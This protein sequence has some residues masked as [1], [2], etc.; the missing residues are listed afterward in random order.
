VSVSPV[1]KLSQLKKG[2]TLI[3]YGTRQ[4]STA[5]TAELIAKTLRAEYDLDVDVRDLKRESTDP[6]GYD[7]IIIGSGIAAD[8]WTGEAQRY[9]DTDLQGKRVAVFVSAA[10]TAGKARRNGDEKSYQETVKRYIDD[11]VSKRGLKLISERAFGGKMSFFGKVIIDNWREDD[12]VKWGE[13]LG[14]LI[15]PER[16]GAIPQ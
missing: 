12:I 5:R 16:L 10:A 7:N 9:L 4:G 6:K 11:V 3:V 1:E 2:K 15:G 8:R 13:E 14:V